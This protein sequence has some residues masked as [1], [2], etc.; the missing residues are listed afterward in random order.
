MFVAGAV[1]SVARLSASLWIALDSPSLRLLPGERKL[2]TKQLMKKAMANTVVALDRKV[3][4]PLPPKTAP[5][6]PPPPPNAPAKPSPLA[7]C[8]KTTT[9]SAMHI[10]T[11]N[12]VRTTI[13]DTS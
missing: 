8:I 3:A 4:A 10:I 6:I 1:P 2:S 13:N 12:M 7:D 9:I 11:C 5:V